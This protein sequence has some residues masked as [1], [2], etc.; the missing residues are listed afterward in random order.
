M[1]KQIKGDKIGTGTPKQEIIWN[2]I[3]VQVHNFWIALHM[4]LQL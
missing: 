4:I 1:K 3:K 2:D